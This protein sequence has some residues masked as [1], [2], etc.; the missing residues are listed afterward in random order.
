[1]NELDEL[2]TSFLH[3]EAEGIIPPQHKLSY[4]YHID[5]FFRRFV[6]P[7]PCRVYLA[8]GHIRYLQARRVTR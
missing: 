8:T 6:F 7:P 1:M 5:G 3:I 2:G 4:R